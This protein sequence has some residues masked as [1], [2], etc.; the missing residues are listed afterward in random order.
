MKMTN[1]IRRFPRSIPTSTA[2]LIFSALFLPAK[3][4]GPEAMPMGISSI[5]VQS[6]DPGTRVITFTHGGMEKTIQFTET[7][8]YWNNTAGTHERISTFL[9]GCV[10]KQYYVNVHFNQGPNK[11]LHVWTGFGFSTFKAKAMVY[12]NYL[13][14]VVNDY[15]QLGEYPYKLAADSEIK[16]DG[17]K[18][19]ASQLK[20]NDYCFV[21]CKPGAAVPTVLKLRAYSKKPI[22]L[23]TDIATKK[24]NQRA[25][26]ELKDGR[27]VKPIKVPAKKPMKG[28]AN[29]KG[30][31]G[32]TPAK[33]GGGQ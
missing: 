27:A 13:A 2:A 1:I 8:K 33:A 21:E 6:V 18:V 12:Q 16:R 14:R 9:N 19:S 5:V 7:A 11:S 10:G 20:E 4:N 32:G 22:K 26:D 30:N 3:A 25:V 31:K 23:P 17:Q 28:K 29:P 24:V 15:I